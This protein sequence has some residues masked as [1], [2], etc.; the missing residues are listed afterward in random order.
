[1]R[2]LL[3]YSAKEVMWGYTTHSSIIGNL[4]RSTRAYSQTKELC[5][6]QPE[7][8]VKKG[9]TVFKCRSCDFITHALRDK[10]APTDAL[11]SSFDVAVVTSVPVSRARAQ[12]T[13]PK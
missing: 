13:R 3:Q 4:S 11:S 6:A 5:V 10:T 9:W 12:I 1:M 8:I 2:K 7:K